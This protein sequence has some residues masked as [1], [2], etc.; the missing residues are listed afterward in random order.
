MKKMLTYAIAALLLTSCNMDSKYN[1]YARDIVDVG[2]SEAAEKIESFVVVETYIEVP[3]I[4]ICESNKAKLLGVLR[5]Y[6]VNISEKDYK[7]EEWDIGP[8][9]T[10]RY[11]IPLTLSTTK[12]EY[13][14]IDSLV[15]K[16]EENGIQLVLQRN[17]KKFKQLEDELVKLDSS[18]EIKLSDV[19]FK[20][21]NDSDGVDLNIWLN[22]SWFVSSKTGESVPT[23]KGW[24]LIAAG[25]D[26]TVRLSDVATGF[27][28]FWNE[29]HLLSI[30]Y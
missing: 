13:A 7:C 11:G 18:I 26:L 23:A 21:S 10:F 2:L 14:S 19:K 9:L 1:L 16:K 4:Q 28:G 6:F 24:Y 17:E 27:L 15:V 20:F 8:S 29:T 22:R 25:E 12:P 3:N 30:K 5:H